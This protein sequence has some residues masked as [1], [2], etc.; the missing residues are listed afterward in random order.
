MGQPVPGEDENIPFLMTFGKEAKAHWGDDDFS[1]TFFFVIPENYAGAVYI[2][3]Y[4]P[5]VGGELDELN[6]EP[7]TKTNFSVYGGNLAYSHKDAQET[8]PI[9]EY[10]SGNLLASKTFGQSARYDQDWYTFGPFNPFEGEYVEK[11]QG[12]FFKI[13]AEGIEGD[14][15][16]LY[17]YFLSTDMNS[18]KSIEGAYALTF[19]YSFRMHNDPDQVSHIYP[20]VDDQTI[21]IKQ[22]NFDWDSDGFIR[23]VSVARQGDLNKVSADNEWKET[24]FDVFEEE[25]NSSLD[26][27]F[28]KKRNPVV[29]NNNVVINVRNQYNELLPFNTIPIGGVPTYKP[30]ITVREH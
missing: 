11:Y 21:S 25:K 10:R 28:I 17:R 6:Q 8:D 19:E 16:N 4:D 26:I 29:K 2:R 15:G 1:Q 13:I 5:D 18:N 24:I 23:V 20:F 3:V 22:V 9:G 7:N 30:R 27:Q 12:Y 14:D